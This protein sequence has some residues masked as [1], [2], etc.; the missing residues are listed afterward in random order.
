LS[1]V[2][3]FPGNN[4]TNK[5]TVSN[6]T[7]EVT[8]E[9]VV[10]FFY[11]LLREHVSMGEVREMTEAAIRATNN[12]LEPPVYKHESIEMYARMLVN[13]LTKTNKESE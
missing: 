8:M 10:C 5:G 13:E 3:K 4:N 9:P 2:I 7:I 6:N 11:I 1:N 12:P